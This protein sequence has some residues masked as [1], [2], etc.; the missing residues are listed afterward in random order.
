MGEDTK[1]FTY[2]MSASL[3]NKCYRAYLATC[4]YVW[5][6]IYLNLVQPFRFLV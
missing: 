2:K 1:E 3:S 6:R 5:D 4:G